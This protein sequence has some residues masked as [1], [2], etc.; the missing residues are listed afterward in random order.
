[1]KKFTE[2]GKILLSW[3]ATKYRTYWTSNER[4]WTEG[5]DLKY[6]I[7]EDWNEAAEMDARTSALQKKIWKLHLGLKTQKA[8]GFAIAGF[9]FGNAWFE[10]FHGDWIWAGVHLALTVIVL[11]F[12]HLPMHKRWDKETYDIVTYDTG[13]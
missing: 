12:W 3:F 1:M 11:A 8:W 7:P 2:H 10:M 4:S 5:R 9:N 13:D 6:Q